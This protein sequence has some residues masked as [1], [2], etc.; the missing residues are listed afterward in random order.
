MS[1]AVGAAFMA[2][3]P[4]VL[5]AGQANSPREQIIRGFE[6]NAPALGEAPPELNAYDSEGKPLPLSRW[7]GQ[8]CVLVFGCLT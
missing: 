6:K 4:A 5:R 7:K 1:L 3:G 8:Y 2:G